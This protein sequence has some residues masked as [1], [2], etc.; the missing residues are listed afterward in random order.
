VTL[1]DAVEKAP[2]R[3]TDDPENPGI[4]LL[5]PTNPPVTLAAGEYL[6]LVKDISQFNVKYTAPAGV[7]VLAWGPGNLANGTEKVQLGKPGVAEADGTRPWIRVDRVVY[8]DGS[9]PEQFPQGVDP[10]P[11]KADGQGSS[12]SRTTS[13]AYGNDATNWHAATPS[14]GKANN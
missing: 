10:W 2:W 5:L 9:H 1:Y 8:S 3:F 13:T 11:A 14:P 7:T 12:L 6:L 4:E